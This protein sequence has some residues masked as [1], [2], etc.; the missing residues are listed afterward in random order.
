VPERQAAVFS[1]VAR[2][3]DAGVE[4]VR[5]ALRAGRAL[6]GFEVDDA[7]RNVVREAGHGEHF[8]H[9]TGHSI[10][11][12]VHGNGANIDGFETRDERRIL[13]HTCFSIE[14]GIYLRG[15]FGV[16]SELNVYVDGAD[17]VVTGLP[18]QSQ[19]VP[20]LGDGWRTFVRE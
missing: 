6:R 5:Q 4:A 9:R 16:R 8:V 10:G 1:I 14:P 13:P 18:V 3:R 17:A 2:A 15:D 11:V 12:E 19:V 20:I 7:V